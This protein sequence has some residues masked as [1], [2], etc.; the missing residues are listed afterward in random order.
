MKS[1]KANIG[2]ADKYLR[3]T[4]IIIFLF[5]YNYF[6]SDWF[7]F[8]GIILALTVVLG[9]CPLYAITGIRTCKKNKEEGNIY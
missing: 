1:L 9:W 8:G 4:A 7:L 6:R 5:L 3:V 2:T